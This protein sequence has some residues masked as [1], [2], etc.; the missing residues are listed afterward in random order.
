MPLRVMIWSNSVWH[1]MMTAHLLFRSSFLQESLV[2]AGRQLRFRAPGARVRGRSRHDSSSSARYWHTHT[3]K[4]D[5]EPLDDVTAWETTRLLW[6]RDGWHT[7]YAWLISSLTRIQGLNTHT[8]RPERVNMASGITLWP[9]GTR[10][11]DYPIL[12][13]V[14]EVIIAYCSFIDV[15]VE[16]KS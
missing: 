6:V 8:H 15:Y 5:K 1:V 3:L 2:I 4:R 14:C 7:G 16:E 9:A 12:W 13:K 10:R 11:L